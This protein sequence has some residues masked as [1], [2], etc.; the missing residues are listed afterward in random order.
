[1]QDTYL[2]APEAA[3]YLKLALQTLY[4]RRK[5]IPRMKG[6]GRKIIYRKSDLDQWMEM[7][8]RK[9]HT[10]LGEWT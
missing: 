10:K 7:R 5:E 8:G 4:N 2:T 1:M 9:P 6:G 3:A